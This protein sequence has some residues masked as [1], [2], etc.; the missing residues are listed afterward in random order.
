MKDSRD[1]NKCTQLVQNLVAV[2][3]IF[4]K[5][6][7]QIQN[8][9]GAGSM[10]QIAICD[11]EQFYREKIQNLLEKYLQKHKISY[12]I[13]SYLS[14]EE[15]LSRSENKVKYD[16]V[17][18]DIS[19]KEL[20]GIETAMQIRSF[21]SDTCIVFVTAFID[22]ALEGY[23][24]NAVRYLLKDT[25]D[26]ALAECMDAILQKMRI[27]QVDFSFTD[28]VRKLYTDNILYVESKKHKSIFYYM[29]YAES[30][31]VNY[32]L[33]EKLDTIEEKLS[34]YGFL[35]IHKSYLVNMKHIRKVNNYT[36]L[37]DTGEELPVPRLRFRKAKEAF[38]AYKGAL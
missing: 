13:R 12:Q 27:A 25:L 29:E 37:L 28:G 1:I 31:I 11:D 7:I 3:P 5:L 8:K 26:T 35:R 20:D 22:Y 14:G 9:K 16:I 19:M 2:F 10:L 32:Q 18:M 23:K 24:V 4:V 36:A 17:F 21:Y 6:F 38:V 15:F 33:Y 30:E 34:E